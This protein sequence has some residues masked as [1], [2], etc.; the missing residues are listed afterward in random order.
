M[1][2]SEPERGGRPGEPG[3]GHGVSQ[4]EAKN[5]FQRVR[6]WVGE[7]LDDDGEQSLPQ[8]LVGWAAGIA[9]IY[10]LF[11][12]LSSLAPG[13]ASWIDSHSLG[14]SDVAAF[15]VLMALLVAILGLCGVLLALDRLASVVA[16][17]A[18]RAIRGQ[19]QS[20]ASGLAAER[21]DDPLGL[22]RG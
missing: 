16:R 17:L 6:R 22:P 8:S 10:A 15:E 2:P 7:C 14:S 19:M 5:T 13:V 3:G 12:G 4:A 9:M 21:D 11:T 1:L 20:S 18:R